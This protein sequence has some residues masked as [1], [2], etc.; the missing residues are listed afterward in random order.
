MRRNYN[1]PKCLHFL[2]LLLMGNHFFSCVYFNTFYN[3]ETSY[4]KAL[5]IIEESPIINEI[6]VPEQAKKLLAEAMENSKI[7]LKEYPDSKYVDNA[8]YIIAKSS[9]LRDEVAIAESYFNQLLRDYPESKFY[10]LSKIWLTYTHLRM[11]KVDV[12]RNEIESIQADAPKGGET[13]YLIY[14]I[15]AEIA[16]ENNDIDNIYIHYEKAAEF[17]PSKSKRISTYGKLVLIAERYQD[18]VKASQY[19][20]A[21][22]DVAPEK[23]RI[24]A[25]MKWITYQRE[26]GN[27]DGVISEIQ[28]LLGMSEFSKEYMQLELELGK[29]YKDRGDFSLAKE[30]FGMIVEKYSKKNETAEAYYQLGFMFLMEDFNIELAR[31][32]FESSRLEKASSF[33]GRESKGLLNK[34][35]R[36]E[37]LL[38]LYKEEINNSDEKVD[39][40]GNDSEI[41]GD[42]IDNGEGENTNISEM[43]ADQEITRNFND[44]MD[45]GA[46]LGAMN[47]GSQI[48]DMVSSP[49][50]NSPDSLLFMIGEMLLY[51]FNHQEFAIEKLKMLVREYPDS[52]FASQSLYV[53]SYYEPDM[54]WSTQLENKFPNSSFLNQNSVKVDTSVTAQ[55][56]IKRD[57]AWSLVDYSYEESFSLGIRKHL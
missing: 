6:E 24:D 33:Y 26:L 9:F 47:F 19:L 1:L 45:I 22:G 50:G 17:A 53:L 23:I 28:R 55:M 43:E 51:D 49:M 39:V 35:T 14:N 16:M 38:D 46:R 41:I 34:I 2:L 36:Y 52:E 56:E 5:N 4:I 42:I 48:E 13:F 11:G 32:Y 30:F 18:K 10:S 20:V 57:Y 15:L 12:A 8:I 40:Q 27:Y 54:D 21:L 37:S 3:A 25:R 29:T 44:G 31:E 7:V